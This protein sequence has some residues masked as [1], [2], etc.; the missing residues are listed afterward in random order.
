MS[1]NPYGNAHKEAYRELLLGC[2]RRR[3]KLY[4]AIP[5]HP[6]GWRSLRDGIPGPVTLDINTA[7]KPDLYCDLNQTPPWHFFPRDVPEDHPDFAEYTGVEWGDRGENGRRLY[8]KGYEAEAD[9]WDEIHA[10][11]VLEHLGQQGDAHA[12]LAQFAEL[13]RILKPGGYLVAEVPSRKSAWLW[14]DPSHRR[15]ICHESLSFLDQQQYI[16]QC[17][18]PERTRTAMS[19]FRNLYR[20][21]FQ[22]IQQVDNGVDFAFVLQAIKPSRWVNP[23]GKA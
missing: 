2:G 8:A 12:F 5:Q 15:V 9:Y 20:A 22:L 21:D 14:G 23:H 13:W 6:R 7:V 3:T 4:S 11:Q 10:Y 18:G 17:D 19:D 1:E 16:L